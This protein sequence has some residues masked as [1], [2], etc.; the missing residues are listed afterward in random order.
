MLSAGR[1]TA[2]R[3][4]LAA[5]LVTV[6]HAAFAQSSL[7]GDVGVRMGYS[8]N[9]SLAPDGFEQEERLGEITAGFEFARTKPRQDTRVAYQAQ[10]VFYGESNDSD[11]VYNTLNATSELAIALD[12][13]YVD[14]FALYDQTLVDATNKFSFN[15]L[16]L[17]GNR[18]DVGI[19]G[20]SPNLRLAIGPSIRG[21]I[22]VTGTTID[23][24]DSELEDNDERV[25]TFTLGNTLASSGGTWSVAYDHQEFD[26][27]LSPTVQFETFDT[28]LGFWLGETVRLFTTQGLESDYALVGR[29]ATGESPGLDEHFWY[30]G[31]EWQPSD[32]N[33]IV[34]ATGERS[35]GEAHRL[36]WS[37]RSQRGGI[38]AEY[39]EEPS[40][41]LSQQL[42]SV[43]RTGELSP[44]DVLDGPRGN[45]FYLQKRGGVTFLLERPRSSAALRIFDERRFDIVALLDDVTEETEQYRGTEISLRWEMNSRA[46]LG[47]T[48]QSAIR[49]SIINVIDDEHR[50]YTLSFDRDLGRQATLSVNVSHER[51]EPKSDLGE[52]PYNENQIIV[53]VRRRFGAAPP[54]G[55]PR[56]FT[57]YLDAAP[58]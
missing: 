16:A 27:E 25:A 3:L 17:T 28:E 22:R 6:T 43:R 46:M 53:G 35:F 39:A 44:I 15:K 8:D 36:T 18:T 20:A 37:Y 23:Y 42:H 52:T 48:A 21:E 55:A 33:E 7:R 11:E 54:S 19:F 40:S 45:L 24:D 14:L 56:R 31:V 30:V 34:F 49:R 32:R 50:Y 38:T 41:Y 2:G 29:P 5:V 26:Y 58:Y 12:R 57:G 9:I 1:V 47:L 13:L 51:A 10:G 4:S